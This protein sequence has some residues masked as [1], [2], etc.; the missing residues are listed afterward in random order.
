LVLFWTEPSMSI[1]FA[2]FGFI[3][4]LTDYVYPV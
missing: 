4:N 3:V 2:P 1:L